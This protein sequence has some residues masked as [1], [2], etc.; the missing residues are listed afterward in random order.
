MDTSKVI[1]DLANQ[2]VD[3]RDK[4]ISE[5][6]SESLGIKNKA[7]FLNKIKIRFW[8]VKISYEKTN[9]FPFEEII[10]IYKKGKLLKEFKLCFKYFSKNK[11]IE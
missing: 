5:M 10:R 1:I 7:S 8:R 9:D 3:K 4:I 11:I 2:M 6:L